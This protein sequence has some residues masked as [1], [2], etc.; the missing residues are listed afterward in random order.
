M[1]LALIAL[2][3]MLSAVCSATETAFSSCNRIRLKK[4]ADG[5][6]KSA[7]KALKI[8]AD[9]DKALTA[10][11]IGNNV[12][13]IA[14]S[15]LATVFF[16]EKFG[17]GSVGIATAVMTVLVLIFGEILPK[18]LAK[19]NSESFS[20]FMA[21]PLSAF[22]FIIT[23]LIWIFA[24]IKKIV[25]DLVGSK[26]KSPSV[27]EEELKYIIEEIEDEGVLEE[28]ESD[29]VR[30]ALDFDEI[31]INSIF[32]PRVSVEAVE[33][34][35]DIEKIKDLFL[36]TKYSR[37]PVYEKDIDHI[38]GVIHQSDFFE[39]YVSKSKND[40]SRI[41]NEPIYI[42]ESK[43]ISETLK[44][45]QKEKVHMAV[46]L[47]QHGGTAGICTLED[48]IEELVG[49]IYDE[50]DEEDTS[51]VRLSEKSCEVSAEL[52]VSDFLERF[53][54]EE[55]DIDTERNSVGG[56]IME[57]LDRIPEEGE[58]IFSP[59]FEMEIHMQDE[60]KI[61]RVKI[62]LTDD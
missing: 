60:Q 37:L 40:I 46:V 15:A 59:P 36:K 25:V 52:S 2:L 4:M 12:V 38:V 20:V 58:R 56:W 11:L 5:G 21:A 61:G 29:L 35:D 24:G 48:I 43:K 34:D 22:M 26:K 1:D 53:G 45:M 28:Q 16:T 42:T 27:T 7:A 9:F 32:V 3:L 31:T 55:N 18:S 23:P 33:I 47:D 57:L 13:N 19:E 6:S 39:M 30:S 50:S 14:S 8:C 54:M 62:T 17:A 51:F 49:E 44:I 41:I 10:I